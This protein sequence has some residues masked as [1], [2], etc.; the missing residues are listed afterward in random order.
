MNKLEKLQDILDEMEINV[1][2]VPP[3]EIGDKEFKDI[4]TFINDFV[5]FHSGTIME[6]DLHRICDGG[7]LL[8]SNNK[9]YIELLNELL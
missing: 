7:I 1:G 5:K 2:L 8:E 3:Y 9:T 4:E 6:K